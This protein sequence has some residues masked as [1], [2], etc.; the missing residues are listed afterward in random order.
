MTKKH[1]DVLGMM[2]VR[3]ALDAELCDAANF[4]AAEGGSGA[5]LHRHGRE[6]MRAVNDAYMRIGSESAS[7]GPV[8]PEAI[9][10]VLFGAMVD[11]H[12]AMEALNEDLRDISKRQP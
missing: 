4:L 1:D 8:T 9:R 6:F 2:A 10:G 7:T 11:L 3:D 5:R 12:L